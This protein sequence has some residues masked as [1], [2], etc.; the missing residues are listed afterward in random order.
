[1][2]KIIDNN[3]RALDEMV[4]KIYAIQQKITEEAEQQQIDENADEEEANPQGFLFEEA[5]NFRPL[6]FQRRASLKWRSCW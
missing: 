4:P 6:C 2:D 3:K 1:M 5:L